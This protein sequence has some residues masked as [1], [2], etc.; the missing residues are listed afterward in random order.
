VLSRNEYRG[1]AEPALPKQMLLAPQDR[2]A[3]LTIAQTYLKLADRIGA[4]YER[5][6]APRSAG[7]QH[8]ER[9]S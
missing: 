3:L 5:A 8:A 2:A 1:K 9:D 7:D 6:T 4:R